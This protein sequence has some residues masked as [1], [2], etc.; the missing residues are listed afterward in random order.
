MVGEK[1]TRVRI[2][3]A[4]CIWEWINNFDWKQRSFWPIKMCDSINNHGDHLELNNPI[5]AKKEMFVHWASI[6]ANHGTIQKGPKNLGVLPRFEP[7]NQLW[8]LSFSL[9]F[10]PRNQGDRRTKATAWSSYW[11]LWHVSFCSI[12]ST[13]VL[14][15]FPDKK[16]LV[17]SPQSEK[18]TI[19]RN[20]FSPNIQN[21]VYV[22]MYV[23][24]SHIYIY[25][26]TYIYIYMF[27]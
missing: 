2:L 15:R 11:I 13:N 4:K 27:A 9:S 17:V 24:M 25:V 8:V 21:H 23:C 20:T 14:R 22:C 12:S 7:S 1:S 18:D 3:T 5:P 10:L 26:Y 19:R 6:M 16:D